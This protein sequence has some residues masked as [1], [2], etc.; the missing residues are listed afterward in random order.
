[1]KLLK[2]RIA[3]FVNICLPSIISI[4]KLIRSCLVILLDVILFFLQRFKLYIEW[5]VLFFQFFDDFLEFARFW[6]SLL[7]W[8]HS[9]VFKLI[10]VLEDVIILFFRRNVDV[11]IFT[12]VVPLTILFKFP[13]FSHQLLI[14]AFFLTKLAL[15]LIGLTLND[16]MAGVHR[17]LVVL[18]VVHYDLGVLEIRSHSF[19][20]RKE[21]INI[22]L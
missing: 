3:L 10:Q 7:C 2:I 6:Q 22:Y 13:N 9:V 16:S 17:N 14:L 20:L 15:S 8:H 18:I 11:L 19:I 1:M 4:S 12:Q 21:C 5:I